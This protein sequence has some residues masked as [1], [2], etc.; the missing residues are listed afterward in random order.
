MKTHYV[1][2]ISFAATATS[3]EYILFCCI[4]LA[5]C[6][7]SCIPFIL[8]RAGC[9]ARRAELPSC[10]FGEDGT[11]S[12]NETARRVALCQVLRQ[13]LHAFPETSNICHTDG[14]R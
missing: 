11:H 9:L 12:F 3:D 7:R 13:M 14:D 5:A 2:C 6:V 10:A 1:Y 8:L 4:F